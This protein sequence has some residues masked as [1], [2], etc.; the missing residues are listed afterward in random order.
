MTPGD[1]RLLEDAFDCCEKCGIAMTESL[2]RKYKEVVLQK[3]DGIRN[4]LVPGEAIQNK[5]RL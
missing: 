2:Q 1:K 5:E 4:E 3:E